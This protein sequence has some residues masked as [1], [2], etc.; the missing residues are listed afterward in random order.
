MCSWET[1]NHSTNA[2]APIGRPPLNLTIALFGMFICYTRVRVIFD[3]Y[4]RP[5]RVLP[6]LLLVASVRENQISRTYMNLR[7][8]SLLDTFYP[9]FAI[10][11]YRLT[12]CV[13]VT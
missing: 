12:N 3:R 2:I 11:V 5:V 8:E 1:P 7:R 13:L 10:A 4:R 9:I 6:I